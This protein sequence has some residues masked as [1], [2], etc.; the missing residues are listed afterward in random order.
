MRTVRLASVCTKIGSGATPRGGEAVYTQEGVALIRSQNVWDSAMKLKGLAHVTDEA[1]RQL[2]GVTVMEGDVLL[3][4]T[5]E[6]VARCAVVDESVLPARVNQHVMIIRPN[7]EL[8]SR[9]LQSFLVLPEVKAEL[10]GVSSGGTRRALTKAQVGAVEVT[11]PPIHEQRAIAEVLGALDD[12][13]AANESLARTSYELA[14]MHFVSAAQE[15]EMRSLRDLVTTQYGLTA[16]AGA[17]GTHQMLRVTDINKQPWI[18]YASAP[19]L[20][21]NDA[22]VAKYGVVAGDILVARMAD[23]GKAGFVEE[24]APQ[25]VFASYLVRLRTLRDVPPIWLFHFLRSR[26][27]VEYCNESMSGSVQ[28]NMNARVIVGAEAPVSSPAIM[29]KFAASATRLHKVM[30]GARRESAALVNLRDAL[31]PELMSGRLRFKDAEK[32]VEEVI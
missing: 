3:N 26:R 31:L 27:Y 10:L 2:E 28:A 20:S 30:Q 19:R 8:D 1:A 15:A 24:A 23:P 5:G 25:A 9:Y 22:D 21:P 6:S 13:I 12:K 4:I 17:V 7:A 16:K 11:L 18:D 14:H 29:E 32:T